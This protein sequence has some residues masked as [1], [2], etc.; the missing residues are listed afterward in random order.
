MAA[1][2]YSD[3]TGHSQEVAQSGIHRTPLVELDRRR[4]AP[5]RHH[6]AS[7]REYDARR[8]RAACF[9]PLPKE[10][11]KRG[12]GEGEPDTV[13]RRLLHHRKLER[14]LGAGSQTSGRTIS[15]RTRAGPFN[16]ENR[17][18]PYRTGLRFSWTTAPQVSEGATHKALH[19]HVEVNSQK[20]PPD[21]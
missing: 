20:H 2:P 18:H 16:G 19:Y 14:T 10:G 21:N 13:C 11:Q 12:K 5:G 3:G 15:A 9:F 6:F 8:A 1:H 17:R 4:H 7:H